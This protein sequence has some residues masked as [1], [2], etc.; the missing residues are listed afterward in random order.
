M[1]L[2]NKNQALEEKNLVL[3]GKTHTCGKSF[4]E[5]GREDMPL[6][7]KAFCKRLI[8]D[9]LGPRVRLRCLVD[10]GAN[11]PDCQWSQ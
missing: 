10:A 7:S 9:N 4:H 3:H 8:N 1:T 5:A 11:F 2:S 6:I